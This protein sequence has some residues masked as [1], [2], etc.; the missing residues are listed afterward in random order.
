MT[1]TLP[2]HMFLFCIAK[3]LHKFFVQQKQNGSILTNTTYENLKSS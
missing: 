3:D 2:L 1:I